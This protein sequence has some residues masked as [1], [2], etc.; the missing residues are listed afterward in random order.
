MSAWRGLVS[1]PTRPTPAAQ[2]HRE[3]LNTTSLDPEASH[4]PLQWV[5]LS[6]CFTD[7]EP[8][9]QQAE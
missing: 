7:E 8:E 9:A 1:L 6:S 5:P 3:S 4:S 2:S